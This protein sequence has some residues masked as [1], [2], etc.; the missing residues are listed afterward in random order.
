MKRFLL[1]LIFSMF[2]FGS[3]EELNNGESGVEDLS[4][5]LSVTNLKMRPG[6]VFKM[7]VDVQPASRQQDITYSSSSP[8][9]ATVDPEG[10]VTA[11]APGMADIIIR[12]DYLYKGCSVT[13]NTVTAEGNSESFTN[14]DENNW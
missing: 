7:E 2:L 4:L 5:S 1:S 9:V 10:I 14:E 11:I 12:L 3:C 13:V 6:E 8:S